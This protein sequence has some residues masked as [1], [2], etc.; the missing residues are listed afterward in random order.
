[1]RDER[2][3]EKSIS[4]LSGPGSKSLLLVAGLFLAR[5][6]LLI[7]TSVAG[8]RG[9]GD[10]W[11]FFRLAQ[12]KG[13]PFLNY[14]VEFPPIFPFL[15]ALLYRLAGGQERVYDYLLFG[16]LFFADAGSLILFHKLSSSFNGEREGLN[17]TFTYLIIMVA[18]PYYWWY[19]DPFAVLLLLVGLDLLISGKHVEAGI[20]LGF[21]TIT[22]L[23]PLLGLAAGWRLLPIKKLLVTVGM[24]FFL[25][26]VVY[27]S[28]Y[29]ASPGYTL[30]SIRSQSSKVSWET[31]WA[32][33]D[34]NLV[35]GSFSSASDRLDPEKASVTHGNPSA[36]PHWL[37]LLIF[38]GLGALTFWKITPH[39]NS[40]RIALVG[41]GFCLLFLWSPGWSVQ[42]VLYLI[43]LAL[44]TLPGWRGGLLVAALILSNLL[45]WPFLLSKGLANSLY[46]TVSLRTLLIVALMWSFLLVL[47]VDQSSSHNQP[48]RFEKQR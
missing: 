28:L 3:R 37:T 2:T 31:V 17:R 46:L 45:E 34:G 41:V 8:L 29:L 26:A 43:P 14:W 38:S 22:K 33:A 4:W 27:G 16:L 24:A 1:M 23:F 39:S 15:S 5:L 13:W 44:L 32:L 47:K 25:S 6:I 19:F 36:V 18:V 20:V 10:F 48:V 42:W 9:F 35:T 30:A 40:Q 21:G 7:T 11:H 12:I